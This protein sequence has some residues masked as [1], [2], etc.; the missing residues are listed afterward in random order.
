[1]KAG[2]RAGAQKTG[3]A[4]KR[5]IA[6]G[7]SLLRVLVAL[8]LPIASVT[9]SGS[10]SA[11]EVSLVRVDAKLIKSFLPQPDL[12]VTE[13]AASQAPWDDP[14]CR[15]RRNFDVWQ[16]QVPYAK[17]SVWLCHGGVLGVEGFKTTLE[18]ALQNLGHD[19][20]DQTDQSREAEGWGFDIGR[21]HGRTITVITMGQGASPATALHF[22]PTAVVRSRD[23]T[24]NLAVATDDMQFAGAG[25]PSNVE[26]LKKVEK[27]LRAV[28]A[29]TS[30]GASR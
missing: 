27:I 10:S 8:S 21:R 19:Q 22:L 6:L 1:L 7:R 20:P 11:A 3:E 24:L 15:E 14:E 29:L 18:E 26:A 5:A 4:I 28:D 30:L 23:D 25:H 2:S 13:E 16:N 9:Y 12:E 17:Y